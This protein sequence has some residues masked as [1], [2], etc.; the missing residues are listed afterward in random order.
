MSEKFIQ[1]HIKHRFFV[2]TALRCSPVCVPPVAWYYET[3]VWEWDREAEQKGKMIA[4][5]DS[6]IYESTAMVNHIMICMGL[7][8]ELDK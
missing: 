5:Y 8:E 1:S 7:L 3:I 4:R 6:G 2:S